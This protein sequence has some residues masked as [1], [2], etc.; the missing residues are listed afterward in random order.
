MSKNGLVCLKVTFSP[1]MHL[2]E[3][4]IRLCP[5]LQQYFDKAII[6][7]DL[8][9]VGSLGGAEENV[10][11]TKF[12]KAMNQIPVRRFSLFGE[13][14]NNSER[15]CVVSAGARISVFCLAKSVFPHLFRRRG[16]KLIMGLSSQGTLTG[17]RKI[18]FFPTC[19]LFLGK[20]N[21]VVRTA[22]S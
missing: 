17:H 2:F 11:A 10:L 7:V 4:I 8:I 9:F 3:F 5:L 1:Q 19:I 6:F 18:L 16:E 14:R 12:R 13:C 21:Y 22:F 15:K 20:L